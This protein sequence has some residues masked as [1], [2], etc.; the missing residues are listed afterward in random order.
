MK[1]LQPRHYVYLVLALCIVGSYA[2]TMILWRHERARIDSL[3]GQISVLTTNEAAD[4]SSSYSNVTIEPSTSSVYLPLVRLKLQ[5]S[6]L[7][8]GLMYNYANSYT[9]PGDK[10]VFPAVLSITTHDLAANAYSSTNQF[11]CSEVVY[12][13]FVTPSY[14]VNPMWKSDGSVKL[15][16]GRTMNIYYA[17]SIPGCE[18]SWQS[19]GINSQ[20][21]ANVLKQAA[22]Y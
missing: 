14:P 13:D 15:G 21:I 7:A 3:D 6:P 10:K 1:N 17:P 20:A 4:S 18:H 16:D 12:A 2:A 5:D 19:N 9:I 11:D 22:S 8:E